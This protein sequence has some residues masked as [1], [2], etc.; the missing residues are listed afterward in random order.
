MSVS[1][2][3]CLNSKYSTTRLVT[4]K[5]PR[6][7]NDPSSKL[8]TQLFFPAN[9]SRQGEGGLRTKGYFKK[10]FDGKPL[11]SVITVVLNGCKY[12]EDTIKSILDQ[13]YDNIEYIIID[14][15]STD[16]TINIIKKYEHII[17][18]WISEPDKG[19][20]D[21]MNKGWLLAG[22]L[23]FVLF[24]GAGD[25]ILNLP[26]DIKKFD[27]SHV[28]FGKVD[29]GEGKF[30]NSKADI[31]LR[32]GNTLHHQA[33]LINKSLSPEPPFNTKYKIYADFDFNQRLLKQG[34]K[35]ILSANFVSYALPGGVSKKLCIKESVSIVKKNYGI[36][37]AILAIV[38]Y[39]YQGVKFGFNRLS[40]GH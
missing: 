6:I 8:Q 20:Y 10:S 19:I 38:Y 30:S 14:G 24:L 18:Y 23:S 28:I 11:V 4:K 26:P 1:D 7:E 22:D 9:S 2:L 31:R 29:S 21:A 15:G 40:I 12:L 27:M 32:L 13:T 5:Q 36:F 39:L 33:L 17:D 3:F 25:K 37:W 35:F 34:I 16:G